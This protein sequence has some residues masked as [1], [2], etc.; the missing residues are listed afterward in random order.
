MIDKLPRDSTEEYNTQNLRK[1]LGI[2]QTL[3]YKYLRLERYG[4]DK[5]EKKQSDIDAVRKVFEYKGFKKGSRII[6]MMMPDIVAG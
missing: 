3:Y 1:K 6:Y 5:S 2:S 4:M